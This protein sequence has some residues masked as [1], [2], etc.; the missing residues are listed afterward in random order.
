MSIP[1]KTPNAIDSN[2]VSTSADFFRLCESEFLPNPELSDASDMLSLMSRSHGVCDFFSNR[3][4]SNLL[5]FLCADVFKDCDEVN[6]E[7]FVR[8]H[9]SNYVL[10]KHNGS[11]TISPVCS[12]ANITEFISKMDLV[13]SS[14]NQIGSFTCKYLSPG[15]TLDSARVCFDVLLSAIK[16]SWRFGVPEI[17]GQVALYRQCMN[18]LSSHVELHGP[19]MYHEQLRIS[20]KVAAYNCMRTEFLINTGLPASGAREYELI[21]SH[22]EG[23]PRFLSPKIFRCEG[24]DVFTRVPLQ[25][26]DDYPTPLNLLTSFFGKVSSY[27][28]ETF[29]YSWYD[30][31]S[32]FSSYLPRALHR[33]KISNCHVV[34]AICQSKLVPLDPLL[35]VSISIPISIQSA[36]LVEVARMEVSRQEWNMLCG[37]VPGFADAVLASHSNR[38]FFDENFS[39][40]LACRYY[41]IPPSSIIPYDD[42]IALVP[43]LAVEK[44]RAKEN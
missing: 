42:D 3:I 8:P 28:S 41:R 27:D 31:D 40:V 36:H 10:I 12:N 25:T 33:P 43:S 18:K 19:V 39:K 4:E 6:D 1:G 30:D 16:N 17:F 23:V 11:G 34:N 38:Y 35:A 26:I 7:F 22:N 15:V 9:G 14:P 32:Y 5:A 29:K 24:R 37:Y 13:A 20:S 2:V 44:Y 21:M